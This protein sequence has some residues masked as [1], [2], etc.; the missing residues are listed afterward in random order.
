LLL[1]YI[2][3][4]SQ[5]IGDEASRRQKLLAKIAEAAECG[6]DFIQLREKDLSI[7]ELELLARDAMRVIRENSP[8]SGTS[9]HVATRLLINSRTDVAMACEADGVHLRSDDVSPDIV[10]EVWRHNLMLGRANAIL[11]IACHNVSEVRAAG[12]KGG[13]FALLGPIFEK[14]EARTPVQ[15]A[16]LSL[17]KD[18]CQQKIPVIA[19]GGITLENARTC[20]DAGAAGIAGIRI[21]QESKISQVVRQLR[22]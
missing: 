5:F 19:L 21:F 15:L 7:H 1:Y 6:V 12:E 4:R 9:R 14:K 16:G 3:D 8:S 2:T 20:I 18:A 11:S 17:L 22:S 13:D 10:R